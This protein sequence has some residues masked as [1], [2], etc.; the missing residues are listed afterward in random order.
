MGY[1][2]AIND[3]RFNLIFDYKKRLHYTDSG[4]HIKYTFYASHL[5]R[6]ALDSWVNATSFRRE[7]AEKQHCIEKCLNA[8]ERACAL[9]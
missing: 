2:K 3:P 4:T 6:K 8:G 1:L 9:I 7:I 5:L